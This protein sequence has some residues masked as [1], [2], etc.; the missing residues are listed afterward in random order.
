M[1]RLALALLALGLL[2]GC[3][4]PVTSGTVVAKRELKV[5]D[6]ATQMA[7]KAWQADNA[8]ALLDE[9]PGAYKDID[10]VMENQ[11]DLV[12]IEHTLT[13]VLNYKGQ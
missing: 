6:L 7:G 13:Q 12:L 10:T 8:R 2:V 3:G 4:E 9:A 11:K 1:R 5:E